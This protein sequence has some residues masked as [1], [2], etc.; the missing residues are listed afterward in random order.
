[1][2]KKIIGRYAVVLVLLLI[3]VITGYYA[4]AADSLSSVMAAISITALVT[5]FVELHI[6]ST[7]ERDLLYSRGLIESSLDPLVTIS[8]E[9]R[10][11]DVNRATEQ[12]TGVSREHLVGS[13]FPDYFTE[14]EKAREGYQQ[15]FSKG[16]VRDYPLAI[17]HS[18]GKVTDVFYNAV[19]Y[20]NEAGKVEGVFAAARDISERKRAEDQLRT[21]SLYARSLIE[22]SLD[23]LVTISNEGKITDVNKATEIVT[24]VSRERLTGSDFLNYFTEPDKAREGYQQVF[25][26]GF[27]KDYPLVIRHSSGKVTD[28]LYN[29]VVYRNEAGEVQG[30]F[31]A[32]RDISERKRAEDQL[33]TASLYARSLIEASLD[34]LVTISNEGKITDVNKA[35]E[36]VTGISRERLTGSDFSDYFTE[37][38][39]AREGYQQVFSKGFVKDYPLAIRHS[40]GKVTDVLYNAVVYKNEGEVQGVFAAARDITDNKKMNEKL[41]KQI[42]EISEA[43]NVLVTSASEILSITTQ[44]A[45][46]ASETA[47]SVS[48]TTATTEEVKQTSRL[49]GDKARYVSERAQKAASVAQQGKDAVVQNVDA[50]NKIKYQ[51]ELVADS[52]VKLSEQSQAI[53]DITA[54]V[55]DL[56]EQSNLLAV[57]AAIE[58]AKAGEQGK[59]FAVVA[60]EIKSLAEQSKQA[61][62]QVRSILNDILKSTSAAVMATE[63][64]GKAVEAGV[65]QAAVA[66]ESIRNLADIVIEASQAATQVA[67]SSQQQLVGIDQI[68]KAMENIKQAAQQNA[69]G[70]KQAE[71]EAHDLNELGQKLKLMV[72]SK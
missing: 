21:A 54:T 45:S 5:G 25:S 6:A 13:D 12:V 20:K 51:A 19:V 15:V 49:S 39:K 57:N 62:T 30:V 52:I 38:D 50:I 27:V 3:A 71:K 18:S 53:G 35:T 48:E 28:V 10:I 69:I 68:S 46:S 11:T 7:M 34:P 60:G 44:L 9:G 33:R 4:L 16:F 23:P 8:K 26:K 36:F 31:A 22:A 59:G 64:A 67:A 47:T 56:A 63:Q 42:C 37:P 41:K 72:E 65:K 66:G 14:P 32:A 58:A 29:A 2:S 70:T 40:S 17:R 43:S 24:G 55:N 1:M 61:T